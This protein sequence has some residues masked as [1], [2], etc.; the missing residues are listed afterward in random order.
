MK[1]ILSLIIVAAI[2][3]CAC[4][5]PDAN[6]QSNSVPP[7]VNVDVPLASADELAR[8][9]MNGAGIEFDDMMSANESYGEDAMPSYVE[10]YYGLASECWND[11]AIYHSSAGMA[12]EV[13][14]FRLTEQA[15]I[16]SVF[17]CLE[18]YRHARQGD[19]FGYNPE[20]ADMVD[21]GI[22]SIGADGMS[23]AVFICENPYEAEEAFY[24]AQ[25][26]ILPEDVYDTPEIVPVEE[27]ESIYLEDVGDLPY[28]WVPYVDP[29]IDDMTLWDNTE[30]VAAVKAGDDYYL[31]YEERVLFEVVIGILNNIIDEDMTE[32][33]K[34]RAVYE[35]ITANCQYDFRHYEVPNNAPRESYEAIGTILSRKAVCLGFANAFQLFMDIL[36]IECITVIGAAYESREDHAWN[37]VCID[38]EWYCVDTTWDLGVK[39]EYF[40]YFN[41]SSDYFARS[42]HQWDYAA[43]PIAMPEEIGSF[44]L[45]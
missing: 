16:S 39:P 27:E 37:M 13:S 17:N 15:D 29:E 24:G 36:D 12:H 35:W 4:G 21:R 32:I 44:E 26:M 42:S 6:E 41:R 9:V 20:Q 33:E 31:S 18:E 14:I 45:N 1:R 19:F 34:E 43:Y 22:V 8:I 11:C 40:N 5:N 25:G 7:M 3:L 38:G 10:N 30:F 28:Y 23:A 2:A